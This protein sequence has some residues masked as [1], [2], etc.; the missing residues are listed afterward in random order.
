MK[1]I[2][3][4]VYN[5][6]TRIKRTIENLIEGFPGQEII[7][8]CD[9]EDNSDDIIKSFSV[10][11]PNIRLLCF[12][13]RLGK[14]GALIQGFKVAEGKEICF[15]DADE[16]VSIDDL[17]GMFQALHGVD[18]VIA[19]RRLKRSKILIKQ[20]IQRRLASRIFNI[21]VRMLFSLPYEDTQCGAKVFKKE[22]I[23][24]ILNDLKTK[25]FETDV[26]I[27]WRLRK[28]GYRIREYP[29]SWKHSERTKF[30]LSD[31]K[32]ML[33]S[34]IRTRFSR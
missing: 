23:L 22:A 21:F 31:S 30:K 3:I 26:E 9:G 15:V 7:V 12:G 4:P 19:S 11:Y 13:N 16:S 18:G 34:L 20:P 10:R 6:E 28:K 5:E 8:V 32:G 2:I 29:I 17:K 33:I 14:G 25:G 24:N 1:S 27:L